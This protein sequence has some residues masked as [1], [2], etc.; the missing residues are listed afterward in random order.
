[1][2]GSEVPW[3]WSVTWGQETGIPDPAHPAHGPDRPP[4]V[5]EPQRTRLGFFIVHN[6]QK[7]VIYT[8]NWLIDDQ[9]RVAFLSP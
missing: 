2:P 5:G 6:P 7:W 3:A 9:N 8:W 4:K 1:M